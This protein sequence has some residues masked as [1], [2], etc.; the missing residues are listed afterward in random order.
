MA[1][2]S[3]VLFW[4]SF[5]PADR[6]FL[7]WFA[8]APFFSLVLR[9]D[10]KAWK[11]YLAGWL[12]G[13]VFGLSA[14]S[15]V[16]YADGTGAF[17]MALFM[18]LWW[19]LV[20]L[21]ARLG[22]N[23]LKL[24][25]VLVVPIVWVAL[26]YVRS[27]LLSGFPWYY[28][29][30]SQYAYVPVIQVCDLAGAWGLSFLM[31]MVNVVVL[32]AAM[33]RTRKF[34]LSDLAGPALVAVV[35]VASI[36]YGLFK[37]ANS[38]FRPGPTVA[39]IQTDFTQELK[40]GL[41]MAEIMAKLDSLL[42]RATKSEPR[43]DLIVWPETSYPPGLVSIDSRLSEKEFARLAESYDSHSTP[44][45]WRER[46][47]QSG[48]VLH[49]LADE[50]KIPMI[51]GV[52]SYEFRPS[53]F[54]RYNTAALFVPGQPRTFVYHKRALVPAGEYMPF[55][56]TLPW[57][58]WLTPYTDY[59]PSLSPGPRPVI[60]EAAGVRY[61]PII[62]FEDTIP[63]VAREAVRTQGRAD[64][65]L[66]LTNDGWFRGSA[67]HQTHLAIS[68]FR[69][70]ECRTPLVRSVNTGVT[71]LID[72]DG[73][74]REALPIAKEGVLNV[75]VPLDGRFSLYL[76]VGDALALGCL[77]LTVAI[78]PVSFF[79]TR[80]NPSLAQGPSVG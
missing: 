42:I 23:R 71:A 25:L 72:G 70:V 4:L 21:P 57:L 74:I 37:L 14:M 28:L 39:L 30:H 66:N 45:D 67:E 48:P 43:P 51:V 10:I 47:R 33:S 1:S 68:V 60:L 56:E 65:L 44:A 73:R 12:G 19:P 77:I 31:A 36:S 52:T 40:N 26:E 78:L 29:A 64:V 5:P 3:A 13:W 69:A 54:V 8:L 63:W 61:A 9:T 32:E 79:Y 17:L 18:S 58:L 59:V 6:G 15:W 55:V 41:N 53:E 80:Q 24:P 76:R 11:I 49:A 2:S 38:R 16:G 35:F 75:Q 27:L 46:A 20:L 50:Y 34:E 62:C 7:G 22:A